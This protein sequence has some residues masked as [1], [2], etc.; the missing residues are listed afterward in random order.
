MFNTTNESNDKKENDV[1]GKKQ[2]PLPSLSL[3]KSGGAIR[4]I[5]EKFTANP[6]NGTG[7]LSVP[8]FT[9]PGRSGFGPQL[10]LS[11]DSGSGNGPFGFGWSLSLPTITRKTDKGLP[12]YQDDAE[13]DVF[14]I[15]GAED[16]VPV[17]K[18]DE[19]GNIDF[20]EQE[21]GD[22]V[23]RRYRP[24]IEGMFAR[25]ERWTHKTDPLKIY[26]RSISK[27]NILTV[28]GRNKESRIADPVAESQIFSWLICESYDDKGNAIIYNYDYEKEDDIEVDLSNVYERNRLRT[29]NRYLKRILYGNRQ[30][31][32]LDIDKPSFRKSYTEKPNPSSTEWMFELVFDYGEGHYK[33][34]PDDSTKKESE[35]HRFVEASVMPTGTWTPR[36]DPFSTY[37]AGFEVRTYRRCEQVLMFHH[38]P[39]ELGTQNYLVR[40]TE[41]EYNKSTLASFIAKVIQSGYVRR[42]DGTYLK[43]SLPPLEFEYSQ[44]VIQEKVEV[45]DTNS[46]ENLPCGLDGARYQWVDLNGEGLS[47]ILTEQAGAWFY[48]PNLGG[49]KFGPIQQLSEKP[50]LANLSGGQQQLMDLAGDGKLD[51]VELR[52]AV[53]GFYERT[54]NQKWKTFVPFKSLPNIDWNDPNLR[55]VDLTGDGHADILITEGQ[56]FTWY[57]SLGEAGFSPNEKVYQALDE[58][59]GPR[60]IFADGTQSIYLADL[61][62]DGLTDIA[63]IKNNEVCYWP[64]LGYARFGSKVTMDNPPLFDDDQFNQQRIRLADIDGSG[65]TDIIYL[66]RNGVH[67]YANQS[68]NSWSEVRTLEQFPQIDNLTSVMAADLLGNGTACLVWSSSLP[69]DTGRQMRYIDL[70]GGQKPHLLISSNNNMGAQTRVHYTASTTFYL[71]DQKA[72]KPWITSIPFP[73]YVVD[74]VETYDQISRNRFVTRYAYHHG[75][76]DGIER[77]FQGFG[78]VEQWDTEEIGT[79]IS[80]ISEREDTNWNKESFIPPVLTRTWFHTGAYHESESISKHF[81]TEYYRERDPSLGEGEVDDKQLEAILLPDTILP[82]DI[83]REEI[84][85]ACRSLKGSILRQEIYALDCQPDGS[86]SEESDRPYTVSE[87]NYTIK[88]LQHRGQNRHAVFFVHPRETI[89]FNY[90]R[91][92]YDIGGHKHA[93]PRVTHSMNLA[94]DDYGNVLQS[95]AIGYGHRHDITNDLLTDEDKNK[96]KKTLVTCTVNSYTNSIEMDDAYRTPLPYEMCTYELLKFSP[97]AKEPL[98]TNLFRFNEMLS[99]VKDVSDGQHEIPYEDIDAIGAQEEGPYRRLIEHMRTYYRKNNLTGRLPLKELESLAL[100]YESFKLAFTPDLVTKVYG[101]RVANTMFSNEG[102]YV[103]LEGDM[104]WWISSGRVFY[105]PGESNTSD[106]ELTFA[107]EHFFLPHRFYDPFGNRTIVLYDSNEIDSAKN[108]NLLLKETHDDLGNKVTAKNDYRVLQPKLMTDPNGNRSA[109][110][111]DA[112]GMVVGTAVMGKIPEPDEKSKGDNLDK[113]EADITLSEIQAFVANPRDTASGLLKGASSRIIYDIDRFSRCS[114]PIFA[115]TLTREIHQSDLGDDASP[116]QIGMTYSDG[117]GREIQ[118][119]IQAEPGDAPEREK[120]EILPS[121]DINSGELILENGEPKRPYP[122]TDHRWVGKGRTVYNNKGKPVKQYEPFFSSTH[123]FEK[124]PEMTDTGVTPVLLYDPVERNMATLHPNH[125]YEKVVFDPWHQKIYDVNDTVAADPREDADISGYV[126]GY[127]EREAPDDD[128]ETW[129]QQRDIDPTDPPSETSIP[130]PE[131]KAAIRTLIHAD[132]PK[133]DF[134][135]TL[136]RAFLTVD[137]NRSKRSDKPDSEMPA[138]EFYCTRIILDIEGNQREVI[139]AKDRIVMSYDY[140]LLGNRIHQASMEAGERWM[141]NNVAGNPIRTWDS[142]GFERCMTYDALQRPLELHVTDSNGN[143]FLAEKTVYGESKKG[144]EKTNHRSKPWKVYDGAGILVSES[145]DFKGNLLLSSRQLLSIS[146]CKEQV[147]WSLNPQPIETFT[148]RTVYDAL[149]RPIQMIAPHSNKDGTKINIIQPVY[150]EA[151]LLEREEVWLE[152]EIVWLEQNVKPDGLLDPTTATMHAVKNIDYN[153]KGQRELIEYGNGAETRY[154]YDPETFRLIHLYS[155]RGAEFNEDCGGKPPLSPSPVKPPKDKTCGLQNLH[156]TYD[157]VGNIIHIRDDAQQT[158]FFNGEVIRPDT[159]YWYD[160]IYRLTEAHG[161]EHV[162]QATVPHTTWN[163]KGRVNLEHP[164]DGQKMRNYFEFYEYDEVGNIQK[165]DHK[166]RDGDWIRDYKY[167][168]DSLIESNMDKQNNYLTCTIVHPKGQNSI[169]EPYSYDSHG[170]MVSMPHFNQTI[171]N[172]MSWDFEDQLQSIDKGGGC[173]VYYTYDAGGQRVRK[174]IEHNGIPKKER[175]YLGGFEVYREYNDNNTS[176]LDR[177][178]LHIMDD[179]QRIAMVETRIDTVDSNSLVRYQLGNHLGSVSLELDE[180]ARIISYEEYYPYGGTSYQGVNKAIKAVAKRYRYTGKERDDES[181]LYYHGARYYAPWLGRWISCDPIGIQD[182]IDLY[183]YAKN[184]PTKYIDTTGNTITPAARWE[185][186]GGIKFSFGSTR[187]ELTPFIEGS[188]SYLSSFHVGVDAGAKFEF[189]SASGKYGLKRE[190]HGGN[191]SGYIG[192]GLLLDNTPPDNPRT[193]SFD[194]RSFAGSGVSLH[195]I[196]FGYGIS[197]FFGEFDDDSFNPIPPEHLRLF[198]RTGIYYGS[199]NFGEWYSKSWYAN[200]NLMGGNGLDANESAFG[201]IQ[202]RKGEESLEL[203]FFDV[204][205]QIEHVTSG[206]KGFKDVRDSEGV[207]KVEEGTQWDKNRGLGIYKSKG[208]GVSLHVIN[209]AYSRGPLQFKAGLMGKFAYDWTQGLAHKIGGWHH[210]RHD[211]NTRFFFDFTL[212]VSHAEQNN[213]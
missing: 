90:E 104:N 182:D 143:S 85:E 202:V 142:R 29:T 126:R 140:D 174:V 132:T 103:H 40:S 89:D 28:Y 6:V 136:G 101:N 35:Q 43:K 189:Y 129:L 34:L 7:S 80:E 106:E 41:F 42:N 100:P 124:E 162:G 62:G 180:K 91:K 57:P 139:D 18:K 45:I 135:D 88:C 75:Y 51:L 25:I 110:V 11:Y 24:R 4:G 185:V 153:A 199:L 5:G 186:K 175:I 201:G 109:A 55:F 92:L 27:D 191:L 38:F 183:K 113:F 84:Y 54:D 93:D 128:W 3:P 187:V 144:P 1:S 170:N 87:R 148:N 149:N 203:S 212:E 33:L 49:G 65:T 9:S 37:R 166:A 67:I 44:A 76:F 197:S 114:Q 154:T 158:I 122:Y 211:Q 118:T 127:F 46:L 47:G 207:R 209:V 141:L 171:T 12:R 77:E 63:R 156:Y 102:M 79:D 60:L 145:Y 119:K 31:L 205:D 194:V 53:S 98:V 198:S 213:Y 138:D 150:N 181:G 116:I 105:S 192:A 137:H 56:V 86:P 159:E 167:E 64:N 115:A 36:P 164:H 121:G 96:Q 99:K 188:V 59:T 39:D 13:S 161:R 163:D 206:T 10:S 71:E 95:V 23:V 200:D 176:K 81:K 21:R 151:N 168:K 30:P 178:T 184:N 74:R 15:S 157:P 52:G 123:L 66:G 8:I 70:M 204:T 94:V 196:V 179:K 147:D 146:D 19:N 20:D 58:D 131:K 107:S 17:L 172:P 73:V 50:S 48:K 97:A 134:F 208:P 112:L 2:F 173:I 83:K 69:G 108:Y 82:D 78:M 14:I 210:H 16:L 190:A 193:N 32:L 133:V 169:T 117:F 155:R 68:G 125:T 72:G 130:D 120:D 61:S 26:W 165:L 111:F 160:A 195:N 152:C 22:Y 177:E